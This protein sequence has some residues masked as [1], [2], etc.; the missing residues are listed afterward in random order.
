MSFGSTDCCLFLGHV[1]QR[2]RNVPI[3]VC[4]RLKG[5]KF[6]LLQSLGVSI[7]GVF[8]A[9]QALASYMRAIAMDK[10]AAAQAESTSQ[11]AKANL[12]IEQGQRQERLRI[13]IE[14]LGH[15]SSSVRL[16]GIYELIHL[17]RETDALRETVLDILCAH[18]RQTTSTKGYRENHHSNP[19]TEVQILL[20]TLF[21]QHVD[22]F[23]GLRANLQG[24]C[25]NRTNLSNAHLVDS[26]LE[27][28]QLQGANLH[29]A[30]LQ[31]AL[32]LN[33]NLSGAIV[34][35]ANL[36]GAKLIASNLQRAIVTKSLLRGTTIIGAA[37]QLADFREVQFQGAQTDNVHMQDA[38]VAGANFC[39][40]GPMTPNGEDDDRTSLAFTSIIRSSVGCTSDLSQLF[41]EGGLRENDMM[42]LVT[43]LSQDDAL[44]VRRAMDRHL[45]TEGTSAIPEGVSVVTG[46]YTLDNANEWV[47]R[48]EGRTAKRLAE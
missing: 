47:A 39:G 8:I 37:M 28:V 25:L 38:K 44:D 22:C 13:A 30:N 34:A 24:A 23:R 5:A 6:I 42:M 32:L 18:V 36:S 12:H 21:E 9:S 26:N 40:V 10:A 3:P 1:F 27:G 15:S 31:G 20:K 14:H 48:Y 11:Q 35:R 41:F 43:G 45:G 17:A 33:A 29:M 19:S 16:G 46:R 2:G 4:R 7:G